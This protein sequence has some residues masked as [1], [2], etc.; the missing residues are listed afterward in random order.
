MM[1]MYLS[2]FCTLLGDG[3]LRTGGT[4]DFGR[5]STV[6]KASDGATRSFPDTG[7]L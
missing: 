2:D 3:T 7:D 6:Y 4:S 1:T 5:R